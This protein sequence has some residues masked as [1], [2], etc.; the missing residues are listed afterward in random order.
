MMSIFA[1][2]V[3]LLMA[4]D[5]PVTEVT[6]H[7]V[8]Q[9]TEIVIQV[10]GDPDYR[11]FLMEGPH[12]LVVDFMG[13]QHALPG[14]N[15]MD[16]NRGGIRAVRTSQYSSEIVRVV[17][18]LE[19]KVSYR[20]Q[21]E[22]G[23]LRLRLENPMGS[24]QPWSTASALASAGAASSSSASPSTQPSSSATASSLSPSG[25]SAS[26]T[27]SRRGSARGPIT[28][29]QNAVRAGI[30][31]Q[32]GERITVSFTE[33]PIQNVLFTFAEF[34]GR[35]I[36]PGAAVSGNVTADIRDQ[37]W[38]VA[39]RSILE[40]QGLV[41]QETESGIIRVDNIANLAEQEQVEPVVTRP[42]R[43]N[44]ATASE[45][46]S[47]IEPLLSERGSISVGQGTNTV[48]VTDLPRI[49]EEV[50]MLL[51]Q[52]DVRTPQVQIAAKIIFV[53]RSDLSE[54]G[55]IYD[56]KDVG[57]LGGNQ[58]NSILP[59][60]ADLDGDGVAEPVEVGT[61]AVALRGESVAAL[62]NANQV[63]SSPSLSVLT[64]LSFGDFTLLNFLQAL[65]EL[66]LSEVQAAPTLSVMDN[67]LAR[68]QVGQETPLR[69]IEAGGQAGDGTIPTAT[70]E[71]R[72]TGI[73]LEVTPHVTANENILMELHAERSN[74]DVA[75]TD[76]GFIFNTQE[77]D[78]RVLV[79]DGET[80]VIA[81]LTV[82]EESEVRA[83][84]PGLMDLPIVGRFFRLTR[85]QRTQE[86]L[87]IL[88]TPHIVRGNAD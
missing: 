36:V 76:V 57:G 27:A 68:V 59:G 20:I 51:E 71:T 67:N 60:F 84:I 29:A 11:D 23:R 21:E 66:N 1:L 41:A 3:G 44:Y 86:D 46:Q 72:E 33:T 45:I 22:D 88:V 58:L 13:A 31:Q 17:V 15:F 8:A 79:R 14:D 16:I 19:R 55:V 69:V 24:F 30:L 56:L 48:I 73:I 6:I 34:S 82:T 54:L 38:D 85:N 47:A 9:E 35:S 70:V 25:A 81:G 83:G 37:P 7:P 26:P 53:N 74:V 2:G 5:I 52:L 18:E 43:V 12:R 4:A 65:E 49:V 32:P 77:A 61:D 28:R 64:T 78:S 63:V 80:V 10:D 42:F 40:A 50:E 87:M 75:S 39:L 62:G